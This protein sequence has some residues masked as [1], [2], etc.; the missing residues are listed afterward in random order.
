MMGMKETVSNIVTS[1]AEK[2]GV[3]H[4]YYVACGG[5]YAAVLMRRSIRRK[6]F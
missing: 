4:V 5:S 6:H 1:Q 3:K 2:G